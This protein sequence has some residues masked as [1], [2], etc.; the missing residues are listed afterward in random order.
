M[1]TRSTFRLILALIITLAVTLILS[2]FQEARFFVRADEGCYLRYAAYLGEKGP[3]GLAAIF[4]GFIQ[5]QPHWFNPNPLRIGFI[6]LSGAW[7]KI[8]GYSFMNLAFLSLLSYAL[9]LGLSYYFSRKYLGEQ[10]A[11]LLVILLAFS[12]L[13]MAMAR[14]ALMESVINL[15]LVSAIWLFW[16]FLRSRSRVKFILFIAVFTGSIL[17][18]ETSVLLVFVFLLYFLADRFIYGEKIGLKIITAILFLPLALAGL[19]YLLLGCFPYI[20]ATL[21]ILCGPPQPASYATLFCSGPWYRYLIDYML[22][23]PWVVILAVGF[24]FSFFLQREEERLSLYFI[25]IFLLTFILFDIFMKN[26]RYVIIL[27][28]PLRLFSL[29]MLNRI[30]E[31]AYPRQAMKLTFALV[32][33]LALFDYFNFYHLFIQEGIYDPASFFLLK[34]Q[35]IIP[36]N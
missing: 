19:A 24:I 22:L 34:A 9:F 35:K 28:T 7:L 11:L 23:S 14:R 2:T 32:M 21:K 30:A 4:Q 8:L 10:L 6:I 18:K 31:R 16:D 3:G 17:I 26:V 12:P 25:F 33:A 15:F 20:P 36:F 5:D 13:Q 29:L 1:A 27:D